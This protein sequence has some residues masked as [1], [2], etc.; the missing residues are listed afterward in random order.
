MLSYIDL[1]K[2]YKACGLNDEKAR[3]AAKNY[4]RIQEKF[5]GEN[6]E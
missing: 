5:Y 2:F 4:M 6:N 1:F 3:A